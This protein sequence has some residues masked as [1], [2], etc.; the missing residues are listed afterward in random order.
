[1]TDS[2]VSWTQQFEEGRATLAAAPLKVPFAGRV[3]LTQ[4]RLDRAE[5]TEKYLGDWIVALIGRVEALEAEVAGLR[6][7]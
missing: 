6:A 5:A 1:M 2:S 3:Y 4:P 7:R